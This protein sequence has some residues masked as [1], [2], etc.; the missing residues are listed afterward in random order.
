M[1][2]K[3]ANEL[4]EERQEAVRAAG[5]ANPFVVEPVDKAPPPKGPRPG[6]VAPA[7]GTAV[8]TPGT[9]AAVAAGAVVPLA[10][11]GPSPE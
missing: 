3:L 11:A 5:A 2:A 1:A 9:G 7:A 4:L 10:A 8:P 6:A